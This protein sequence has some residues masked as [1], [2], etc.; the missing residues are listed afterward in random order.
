M[1]RG[2]AFVLGLFLLSFVSAQFFGGYGNYN[3]F[4]F[5]ITNLLDSPD[6]VLLALFFIIAAFIAFILRKSNVFRDSN[7]QH[8]RGV[9]AVISFS[10]SLIAVYGIYKSGFDLE[11]LFSGF[12]ISSGILSMLIWGAIIAAAIFIIWQLGVGIFLLLS[13][14]VIIAIS[15]FTDLIY[16]AGIALIIGG[17]MVLVGLF[18]W[19]RARKKMMAIGG[20]YNWQREKSQWGGRTYVLILGVLMVILGLI[21]NQSIILIAG[22]ALALIGALLWWRKR[23]GSYRPMDLR[24]GYSPI[25]ERR[26]LRSGTPVLFLGVLVVI[27]GLLIGNT[28]VLII[29]AV[30]AVIGFLLRIF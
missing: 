1:K 8:N 29:G 28:I 6:A 30:L 16:A 2:I 13:G 22:I 18:L 5:S 3:N 10:I 12:G 23:P 17:V 11:G 27:F 26:Q 14:L 7:G 9:I 15:L 19:R 4:S 24:K 20:S 21:I 25:Q